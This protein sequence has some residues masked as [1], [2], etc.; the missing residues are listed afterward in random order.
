MSCHMEVCLVLTAKS[1]LA[2]H[3][4]AACDCA[5]LPAGAVHAPSACAAVQAMEAADPGA[6][7]LMQA[8]LFYDNQE[9]WQAPQVE[10]RVFLEAEASVRYCAHCACT[11][12]CT[13]REALILRVRPQAPHKSG[14]CFKRQS[15]ERWLQSI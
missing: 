10:V 15:N 8:W 4:D 13:F 3:A 12:A 1:R 9:F 14:S 6:K 11:T 5:C 2:G 7:W